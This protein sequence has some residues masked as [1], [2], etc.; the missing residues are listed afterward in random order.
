MSE[1]LKAIH[2]EVEAQRAARITLTEEERTAL[3]Y[4]TYHMVQ[5]ERRELLHFLGWPDELPAAG[6]D[7]VEAV[8]TRILENRF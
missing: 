6:L 4:A 2:D 5:T 3:R 7:R 1:I 8:V